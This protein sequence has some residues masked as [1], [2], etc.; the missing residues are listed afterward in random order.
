MPRTLD[1]TYQTDERGLVGPY[2]RSKWQAE[3]VARDFMDKLP[4]VIVLPTL[5]LGP[6]DRRLTPPSRMLLDF[7]SGRIEAYID[8]ILNI[9]DVRD[10]AAGHR[11]A[12]VRGRSGR[13]YILNGH[14]L[15]M[16]SF[17]SC[18][19]TP[20]QP[21]H[22]EVAD[23]WIRCPRRQCRHGTLVESGE[24]PSADCPLSRDAN[25]PSAGHLRPPVGG[26]GAWSSKHADRKNAKRCDQLAC[27]GRTSAG[28]ESTID[29]YGQGGLTVDGSHRLHAIVS[30]RDLHSSAHDEM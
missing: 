19:E 26:D 7:S 14:S 29:R 13:R 17:L 8:C 23:P 10:A 25:Q 21:T 9:I 20:D 22:A 15:S 1:E 27:S 16:V 24:R 28:R 4:I 6:G 18:L 30:I 3:K 11:L 5:P 2:A 12:C